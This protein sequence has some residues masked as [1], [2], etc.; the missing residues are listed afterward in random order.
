MT[1]QFCNEYECNANA[2]YNYKNEAS[3]RYC[4]TH[5]QTRIIYTI[6]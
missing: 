5:V 6:I 1:K 3:Y 2:L 4:K